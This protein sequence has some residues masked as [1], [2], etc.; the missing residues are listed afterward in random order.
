LLAFARQQ[1]LAP[2]IVNLNECVASMGELLRR[3]LGESITIRVQLEQ[4][5]INYTHIPHV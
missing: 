4:I 1:M 2:R 3:A 5:P